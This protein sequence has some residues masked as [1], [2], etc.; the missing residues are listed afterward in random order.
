MSEQ[1]T[2]GSAEYYQREQQRMASR[3]QRVAQETGVDK[4]VLP[5]YFEFIYAISIDRQLEKANK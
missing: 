2:K 1:I 3:A 5:S 4:P